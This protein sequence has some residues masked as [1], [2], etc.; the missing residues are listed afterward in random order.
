MTPL[1]P[2]QPFATAHENG[3]V[4]WFA[5]VPPRAADRLD[6]AQGGRS[7]WEA[8][9]SEADIVPPGIARQPRIDQTSA[10]PSLAIHAKTALPRVTLPGR[11][12]PRGFGTFCS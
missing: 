10:G 12:S 4:G 5:E 8:P 11:R 2:T 1:D 7:D 3:G 6:R 9:I